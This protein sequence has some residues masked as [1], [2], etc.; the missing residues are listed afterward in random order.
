MLECYLL[1]E[2]Y[3]YFYN[4]GLQQQHVLY[5]QPSLD[6]PAIVL[7][8]PN[9]LSTDGT[10]A[11]NASTFSENGVLLAYSLSSGG[12]DW[13]HIKVCNRDMEDY[14]QQTIFG[15]VP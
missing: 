1:A 13:C 14:L 3:Y 2:R 5:T 10:I 7:L 4:S 11:L 15:P 9:T 8:D 12:S 6:S